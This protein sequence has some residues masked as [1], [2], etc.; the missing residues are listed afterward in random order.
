M[1]NQLYDE[2]G[3]DDDSEQLSIIDCEGTF[4][5]T[6]VIKPIQDSYVII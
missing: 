6:G 5:G 2:Y 1:L 4:L 3:N